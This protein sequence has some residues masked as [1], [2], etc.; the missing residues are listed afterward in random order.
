MK[1]NEDF[2]AILLHNRVPIDMSLASFHVDVGDMEFRD[3]EGKGRGPEKLTGGAVE[4]PYTS[5]LPYRDHDV[6]LLTA[7]NLGVDPFDRLGI[8]IKGHSEEGSLVGMI[9]I[10]VVPWQMLIV[11]DQFAGVG[12]ECQIGRASCRERV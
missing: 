1:A 9:E 3:V 11:P 12:I 7:R 2:V 10:P 4:Y 8:R 5:S 6:S